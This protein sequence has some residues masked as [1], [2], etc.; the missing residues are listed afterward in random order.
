MPLSEQEQRLL[1]EMERSLYHGDG[2]FVARTKAGCPSAIN[3]G[4]PASRLQER[5]RAVDEHF[6]AGDVIGGKVVIWN[7][8]AVVANWSRFE[9]FVEWLG[10]D[11]AAVGRITSSAIEE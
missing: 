6:G 2:D 1:D 11:S 10:G 7:D 8:H 4:S 9:G 3:Q 5:L